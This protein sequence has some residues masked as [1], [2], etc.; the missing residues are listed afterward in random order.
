MAVP[1]VVI[2]FGVSLIRD[3]IKFVCLF[4][5]GLGFLQKNLSRL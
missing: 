3:Q 1:A 4:C 2:L 5:F